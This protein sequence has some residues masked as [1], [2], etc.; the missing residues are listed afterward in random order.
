MTEVFDLLIQGATVVLPSGLAQA[1]VACR[2]GQIAKIISNGAMLP[3]ARQ[4]I[5]ARGLWLLPGIIDTQVHFREP[6]NAHK[7]D[8]SSGTAAAILGGVTC[9]FDMPNTQ[10]P[11][12]SLGALQ[13]KLDA[14]RGRCRCDYAFFVGA[15]AENAAELA[16]LEQEPGCAGVKVFMGS[17]T[18]SLLVADDSAL[19][20]V[21]QNGRR[22]VAIHAEDDE[23]LQE[24]KPLAEQGKPASHPLW[25]DTET[26]LRATRRIVALAEQARRPIHVLHVT[27]AEELEFLKD[28]KQLVTVEATPQHLT[29]AA[30]ECYEQLGTRAQM[31]PPI[32]EARH[33]A[34]LWHAV[35]SGVVDI[36]GSDHAPHTLAEKS[37]PYP[38]SPS[39]MPGVQTLLPLLLEHMHQGQLTLERLVDLCCSGPARVYGIEKKGSILLGF[40]AD[41]C[42]VD[43]AATW[44]LRDADQ[45]TRSGWTP[46]DGMTVHGRPTMTV[47]RGHIAMQDGKLVGEA[48]GQP[49]QFV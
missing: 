44:T 30:P 16:A 28:H 5:D 34:A 43:P 22:R 48:R 3:P 18:G 21:L 14:A 4:V 38:Q 17:S 24:R 23:R 47:L 6:G 26:A 32:R 36:V 42:L 41:F 27:S 20:R 2:S 19:L 35:Q 39:G 29:L 7:E 1:S 8:L 37:L 46:F 11:I 40:D 9:I 45:A 25:R 15:T 10:P 13:A 31:N 49:V 33:R 12:T